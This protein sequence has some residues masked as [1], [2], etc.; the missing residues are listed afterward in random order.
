MP[1]CPTC[2]NTSCFEPID[3]AFICC[4]CGSV[5]EPDPELTI[6]LGQ[7]WEGFEFIK[8]RRYKQ[9]PGFKISFIRKYWSGKYRTISTAQARNA[10][11]IIQ[12]IEESLLPIFKV[13]EDVKAE[14]RMFCGEVV[15]CRSSAST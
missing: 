8:I 13:P 9:K 4:H 1:T 11:E 15:A 12:K 7:T 6:P 5:V 3:N 10:D 2:G 14:I